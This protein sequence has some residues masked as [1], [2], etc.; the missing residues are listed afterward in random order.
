[1]I[2]R[3]YTNNYDQVRVVMKGISKTT[4]RTRYRHFEFVVMS[5][6][7]TNAPQYSWTYESGISRLPRQIYSCFYRLYFGVHTP[8]VKRSMRNLAIF[9]CFLLPSKSPFPRRTDGP[10]LVSLFF[11]LFFFSLFSNI[12]WSEDEGMKTSSYGNRE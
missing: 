4:F 7:L 6:G 2:S 1:M 8:K 9:F 10:P 3:T 11:L 5:F 12:H